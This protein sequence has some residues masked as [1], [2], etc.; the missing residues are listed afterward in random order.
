MKLPVDQI[1]AEDVL[2]VLR[3]IWIRLPETASRLRGRIETIVDFGM[4]DGETRP[5]PARWKG[6]LA[7]KLPKPRDLGKRC[8]AEWRRR[9]C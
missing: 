1:G 8:Q 5:N 4:P 3:P 2:A 6:R 7:N 9:N